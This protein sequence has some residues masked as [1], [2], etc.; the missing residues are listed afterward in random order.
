[1][2]RYSDRWQTRQKVK[3]FLPEVRSKLE[4][5][6]DEL[7]K[8]MEKIS[9]KEK[10]INK[11]FT[12]FVDD[13]KVHAERLKEV[14]QKSGQLSESYQKQQE[15]LLQITEKLDEIQVKRTRKNEQNTMNE[16]GNKTTDTSPLMKIKKAIHSLRQEIQALEIRLGVVSNTLLQAKIKEKSGG[17]LSKNQARADRVS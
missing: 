17:E 8:L 3:E 12:H 13:Y 6:S 15:T 7:T 11:N 16:Q 9:T 1:M 14:R 4:K 5:T 10:V 2:E